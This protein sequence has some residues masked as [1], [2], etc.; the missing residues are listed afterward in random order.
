M[1][2]RQIYGYSQVQVLYVLAPAEY[3]KIICINFSPPFYPQKW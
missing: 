1:N 2:L 3:I